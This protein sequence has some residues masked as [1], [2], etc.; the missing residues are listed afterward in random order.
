MAHVMAYLE[1]A[2]NEM[3]YSSCSL[4]P[5]NYLRVT[6]ILKFTYLENSLVKATK[7][8]FHLIHASKWLID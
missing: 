5:L 7:L 3:Q 4:P 6:C 1:L 2:I 8:L